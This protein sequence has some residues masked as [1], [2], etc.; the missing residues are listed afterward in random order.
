M[1]FWSPLSGVQSWATRILFQEDLEKG[2]VLFSA[3]DLSRVSRWRPRPHYLRLY[4]PSTSHQET[5][6]LFPAKPGED[7]AI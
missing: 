3:G 7:L 5:L 4:N 6:A 2:F 1:L